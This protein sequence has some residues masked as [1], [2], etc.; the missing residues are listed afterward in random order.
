MLIEHCSLVPLTKALCVFVFRDYKSGGLAWS[1]NSILQANYGIWLIL[2][3][4]N[5][6]SHK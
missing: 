1:E 6:S 3:N 4:W 2:A 5:E